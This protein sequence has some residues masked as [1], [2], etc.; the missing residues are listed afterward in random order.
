MAS[1]GLPFFD[2]A[3]GEVDHGVCCKGCQVENEE[4][5]NDGTEEYDWDRN[6]VYSKEAYLKHFRECRESRRMW[7]KSKEGTV[8]VDEPDFTRRLGYY[9]WMDES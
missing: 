8:T 2:P 1:V 4:G 6:F 5:S 7:H 3:T 9:S